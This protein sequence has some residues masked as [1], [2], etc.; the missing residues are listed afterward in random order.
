MKRLAAIIVMAVSLTSCH[1][2]P[3]LKQWNTPYGIPPFDEIRTS[4][5]I[6]AVKEGIKQQ[7]AEI[8]AIIGDT[9]T[10]SFENTIAALELSGGILSKVEG[11]LFNVA[12]T[13]RTEELD[14]VVEEAIGLLSAHSTD[15]N[16]NK[17]LYARVKAVYEADQ[18]ALTREQQM[19]LK[20]WY[21]GFEREGIGLNAEQQDELREINARVAALNQK[22]G[23]NILAESN[24]FKEKFGFSVSSYPAMMTTTADRELRRQYNEAYRSRGHNGNE[25]DNRALILELVALRTRKANILGYESS[26]A[27]TLSDKMASNPQIQP[28]SGPC[29]GQAGIEGD[30][31]LYGR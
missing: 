23:N 1:S 12:E 14:A 19:V 29:Q 25:Y 16:F 2:N 10:P 17:A 21:E 15:I 20:G 6:P 26:A 9:R 24:A 27:F 30:A 4:D 7:N 31:A 18:S 5:Y 13:D 3:F 28:G 8:D 11:V 22:I